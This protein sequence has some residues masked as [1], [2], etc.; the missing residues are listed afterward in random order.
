MMRKWALTGG[1]ASGKS[2]V[3]AMFVHHGIPVVDADAIYHSLIVPNPHTAA[4]SPLAQAIGKT[5]PGILGPD[6]HIARVQLGAQVFGQ[7]EA[8]ARL[9]AIT[10]PAVQVACEEQFAAL[11]KRG[12]QDALYDIPLLFEN[13]RHQDFQGVVVVWVPN[14][15]QRM[16]LQKRDGLTEAACDARLASQWRLDRKRDLA[17]WVIDNSGDLT[18]TQTQVLATI[19][20]IR[21][22]P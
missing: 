7:P 19:T 4:P 13:A 16:R 18:Q 21:N 10:H 8:L 22:V 6:G 1:I 15:M 9:N 14:A 2:T 17:T 11:A 3:A 5:F 20:A 12:H